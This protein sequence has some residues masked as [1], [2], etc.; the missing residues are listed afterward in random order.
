M[1]IGKHSTSSALQVVP[2]LVG[3]LALQR[4]SAS[5]FG[6]LLVKPRK[7]SAQLTSVLPK[8]FHTQFV[9]K[10]VAKKSELVRSW[11]VSAAK[12]SGLVPTV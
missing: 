2:M 5:G 10:S 9:F 3:V 8:R 4:L 12:K 7:L 6:Y 1:D 11:F